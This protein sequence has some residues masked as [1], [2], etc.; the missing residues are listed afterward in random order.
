[1]LYHVARN[2]QTFGPYTL[3]EMQRY[4]TTGNILPTDMAR[5]E[6]MEQWL[7]V[8][9]VLGGGIGFAPA[10]V[11]GYPAVNTELYPDPPD[12]SWGLV[13]LFSILTCGI[14]MIAWNVVIAVWVRRIQPASQA[15][16]FYI[17]GGVLRLANSGTAFGMMYGWRRHAHFYGHPFSGLAGLVGYV[18]VLVALFSIKAT[19]EEHY[20]GP[21]PLGIQLSSFMTF[22]FGGLYIQSQLN[23]INEI[24]Q[25]LRYRAGVR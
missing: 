19:L 17:A 8:S 21:E 7:P 14:F 16:F 25:S 22:L 24:K 2:G 12:L 13:L 5:G 18:L 23:R 1:M 15:L 10:P 20:N 4:V 6:G 9:Q 3:E 11:A